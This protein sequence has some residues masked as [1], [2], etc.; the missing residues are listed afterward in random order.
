M[1][2]EGALSIA[3]PVQD[4]F[5][6][7]GGEHTV[8]CGRPDVMCVTGCENGAPIGPDFLYCDPRF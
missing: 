8:A 7:G 6:Q 4:G 2:L 1:G 3:L 5:A